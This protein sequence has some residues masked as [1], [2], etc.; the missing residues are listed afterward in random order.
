MNL[1][2]FLR[3]K[4]TQARIYRH[5]VFWVVVYAFFIL[6]VWMGFLTKESFV[7]SEM[8]PRFKSRF[9]VLITCI[10]YTYGIV[11]LLLPRFL[12][13][14]KYSAFLLGVI[15]LTLLS[16]AATAFIMFTTTEVLKRATLLYAMWIQTINFL[17]LGPPVV[18]GLFLTGKVVKTYFEKMDEKVGLVKENANAELQMLKAQVHPHFLFN[19]LN[20]IYSFTLTKSPEASNLVIK[21]SDMLKYMTDECE[22]PLVPLEKEL[23]V[24]KDYIDLEKVRYGNLKLEVT[25]QGRPEGKLIAPLLLIPFVENSFKHGS[26]KMLDAPWISL[27]VVIEDE[28]LCFFLKNSRPEDLNKHNSDDK[29]IGLA[30]VKKRLQ[31]LYPNN[32]NLDIEENESSFSVELKLP[33]HSEVLTMAPQIP[34][35]VG[36][37]Q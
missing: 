25:V 8:L 3:S 17:F 26:S 9:F 34:K 21:L 10:L 32:Y 14:R 24:L 33:L 1:Y 27:L 13:Q 37:V 4:S 11:Y 15:V 22:H 5:I 6:S 29:G 31:L 2:D 36:A 19:T 18:G 35:P 20:N 12:Y 16:Y 28:W 23:K 30:N 7:F